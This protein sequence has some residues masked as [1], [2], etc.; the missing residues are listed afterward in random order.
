ETAKAQGLHCHSYT[1]THIIS[2]ADNDELRRYC[3][4]IHTPTIITADYADHLDTPCKC[5]AISL[6]DRSKLIA[7]RDSLA[8]YAK[9][10]IT[11]LSSSPI[12]LELFPAWSGKGN[13]LLKLCELLAIPRGLTVA[14]GDQENDLDMLK[15][16]GYSIAMCNGTDTIKNA[17]TTVTAF[18]NDHDGLAR[19]LEM[20][21]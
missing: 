20:L 1:E 3:R 2:P 16:A 17:A 5:L 10:S 21:L 14:A 15:M 18:D 7:F 19:A 12:F 8:D 13:A 6:D 9:D 11:M 4:V